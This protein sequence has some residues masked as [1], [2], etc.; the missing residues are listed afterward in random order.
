MAALE[1]KAYA[2]PFPPSGSSCLLR[3]SGPFCAQTE[4]ETANI[5]KPSTKACLHPENPHIPL[6]SSRPTLVVS[7][8]RGSRGSRCN[9]LQRVIGFC[10]LLRKPLLIMEI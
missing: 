2:G 7:Y 4:T 1:T 9:R 10:D 5:I 6:P 3:L 8:P